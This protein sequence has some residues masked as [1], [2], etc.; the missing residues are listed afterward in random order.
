MSAIGTK[1]TFL[2]APH[3]SAIGGKADIAKSKIEWPRA[4][5]GPFYLTCHLP[6]CAAIEWWCSGKGRL[7]FYRLGK[8]ILMLR[9]KS[10]GNLERIR[11]SKCLLLR[12][13]RR[14]MEHHN[15]T[16][17]HVDGDSLFRS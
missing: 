14:V 13:G 11:T 7:E 12:W 6:G 2:F 9:T 5:A 17:D 15:G 10:N 4:E 3:T 8:L 16:A 1:R